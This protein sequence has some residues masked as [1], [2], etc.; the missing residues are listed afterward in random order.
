MRHSHV[1]K[2]IEIEYKFRNCVKLR[3]GKIDFFNILV[4]PLRSIASAKYKN[5]FM[6]V[7]YA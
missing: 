7:I 2:N 3:T 5:N 1:T 6:L 4:V